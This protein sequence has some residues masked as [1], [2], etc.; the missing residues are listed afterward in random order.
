MRKDSGITLIALIITIIVLLILATVT[1]DVAM[2]GKLFDKAQEA[3]DKTNDKVAQQQN[4]VDELMVELEGPKF[5]LYIGEDSEGNGTEWVAGEYIGTFYFEE[6]DTWADFIG[7]KAVSVDGEDAGIGVL[8]DN[9]LFVIDGFAGPWFRIYHNDDDDGW[10]SYN[11]LQY[12]N[13]CGNMDMRECIIDG[14]DY[15]IGSIEL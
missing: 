9:T 15:V 8:Y 1:V 13:V 2:D 11:V 14:A 7:D 6:G 5:N 4:R 12:Q 3:V 10:E